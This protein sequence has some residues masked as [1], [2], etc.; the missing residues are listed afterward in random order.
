MPLDAEQIED[1]TGKS[2]AVV[3]NSESECEDY[4]ALRG[5]TAF[6]GLSGQIGDFD[7]KSVHL[8]R[9]TEYVELLGQGRVVGDRSTE[10]QALLF[11][12]DNVEID[13]RR[14]ADNAIPTAWRRA[15]FEAA[16]LSA[17]GESLLNV[18]EDETGLKRKRLDG[19]NEREWFQ[20]GARNVKRYPV[21]D[22][23][24]GQVTYQL[25][26]LERG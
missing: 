8:V 1:G 4:L 22:E 13:G 24:I 10:E 2:T 23:L 16:E 19:V 7:A 21:V 9:G 15:C 6:V 12:R 17:A 26:Y 11:P 3:Y 14:F 25:G 5:R 18:V 20:A